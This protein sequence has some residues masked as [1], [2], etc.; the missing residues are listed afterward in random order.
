MNM[1]NCSCPT[2]NK[3]FK[4]KYNFISH[5]NKKTSCKKKEFICKKCDKIFTHKGHYLRHI[6]RK[7]SCIDEERKKNMKNKLE[8]EFSNMKNKLELE[9][10][11]VKQENN[12]LKRENQLL[13]NE[14]KFLKQLLIQNNIGTNEINGNDNTNTNSN[15]K[16]NT[17]TNSNNTNSN[18]ITLNFNVT[19]DHITREKL[20]SIVEESI[21][22]IETGKSKIKF[23][24][25]KYGDLTGMKYYKECIQIMSSLI[26]LIWKNEKVPKNNIIKYFNNIFLKYTKDKIWQEVKESDM[27]EYI[28]E[29]FNKVY[30]DKANEMLTKNH[31]E[32]ILSQSN[33][34]DKL[35]LLKNYCLQTGMKDQIKI[36]LSMWQ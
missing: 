30:S 12:F 23:K 10:S 22:L 8:L 17:N 28:I 3:T 18:N 35:N 11:N 20:K 9:I 34:Q 5:M 36:D 32:N 14:N 26:K 1:F 24:D 29:T 6:N 27:F 16:I 13:K 31:I 15:N 19:F 25:N 21:N 4:N 33:K 7:I 2:C